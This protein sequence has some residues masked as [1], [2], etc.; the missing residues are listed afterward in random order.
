MYWIRGNFWEGG[1]TVFSFPNTEYFLV[2]MLDIYVFVKG[3]FIGGVTVKSRFAIHSM[4]LV[5]RVTT[6]YG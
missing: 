4:H 6:T 5:V 2:A 3:I 1:L